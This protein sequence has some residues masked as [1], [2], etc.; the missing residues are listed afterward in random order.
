MTNMIWT[1]QAFLLQLCIKVTAVQIVETVEDLK[2]KAKSQLADARHTD[3]TASHN[4]QLLE[5]SLEDE[6]RFDARSLED[7]TNK[8]WGETQSQ[9]ATDTADL[10]ITS[11]T[12]AEDTAALADTKQ[13]CQAK[14]AEFEAATRSRSEEL[15][16][17]AKAASVLSA[18]MGGAESLSYSLTLSSFLQLSRSVLSIE[19]E[20]SRFEAVRKIRREHSLELELLASR[21]A[22]AVHAEGSNG[23]DLFFQGKGVDQRHDREVGRKGF[24]GCQPE[25]VRRQGALGDPRQ[26]GDKMADLEKAS[27]SIDTETAKFVQLKREVAEWQTA[28]G[29]LAASQAA[30]TKLSAEENDAFAKSKQDLEDCIDGVRTALGVLRYY[31]GEGDKARAAAGEES[32]GIIGLLQ[33]IES[34]SSINLSEITAAEENAVVTFCGERK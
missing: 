25:G 6:M 7:F 16:A 10:K 9:L 3:T 14:A 27:S 21:V 22:S 11:D 18:K 12:L 30:M 34:D 13:D 32:T 29:E 33:V 19:G 28:L 8:L 20:L 4:S 2:A 24:G 23:D 15:E 26:E 1:L 17:L 31:Y 5:Q